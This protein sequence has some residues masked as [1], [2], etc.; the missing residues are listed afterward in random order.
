M[1]CDVEVAA[2]HCSWL[3]GGSPQE[4]SLCRNPLPLPPGYRPQRPF[5]SHSAIQTFVDQALSLSRR[6]QSKLK[7]SSSSHIKSL[8]LMSC[9]VYGLTLNSLVL[10]LKKLFK[11]IVSH[12][13]ENYTTTSSIPV[14]NMGF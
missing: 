10:C 9:F 6:R 5:F 14:I 12:Q 1:L 8:N 13:I 3:K 7:L 4:L 11:R 2:L